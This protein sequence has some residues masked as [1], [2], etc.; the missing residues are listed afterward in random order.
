MTKK[1]VLFLVNGN[2]WFGYCFFSAVSRSGLLRWKVIV[3]FL[4]SATIPEIPPF[5]VFAY[6]F[7]PTMPVKKPTPPESTR[8]RRSIENLK[9]DGRTSRLTGDENLTPGLTWNVYVL[10]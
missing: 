7:A 10:P 9:S 4:S 3:P 8:N 5:R 1:V 2:T 6:W